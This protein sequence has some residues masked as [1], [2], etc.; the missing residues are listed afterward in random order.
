MRRH[1]AAWRL[2]HIDA[3]YYQIGALSLLLLYGLAQLHLDLNPLAAALIIATVLLTQWCCGKIW[4]LPFEPKSA[5]I[6]GL[7]LCLLGRS[8]SL[9]LY[10]A[11]AVLAISSKFLLHWRGK[12]LFNPTN[13]A[14]VLMLLA[15]RG[16]VWVSPAQW[17]DFAWFAFLVICLG[18]LVVNRAKR[19]DISLAFLVAWGA[20]LCGRSLW[21]GEPMTIPLHR[22][23][24]GGLLVFAFF[25]ISDP[26]TTPDSKAGRML[27]AGL[28]TA[29]AWYVQFRLFRTNGLLWSLA[30]FSFFVPMLDRLFPGRRYQWQ[31]VARTSAIQTESMI[32]EDIYEPN[33][34]LR[35]AG[36]AL[37]E[38]KF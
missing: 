2:G 25:M 29:G 9:V 20:V 27:F 38:H 35:R 3:R 4:K 18:G 30:F 21:L 26:K 15:G 19:A 28:V 36:V 37:A 5:L 1:L 12:H 16:Q 10:A 13:F 7:S 33:P 17:G 6:S 24:N 31:P 11:T 34:V 8:N 32:G 14:L 23:Q 22:L